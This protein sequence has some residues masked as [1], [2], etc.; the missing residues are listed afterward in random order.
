MAT[1]FSGLLFSSVPVMNAWAFYL[2][3]A[4]LIDTFVVRTL[5]VPAFMGL[6]GDWSWWPRQRARGPQQPGPASSGAEGAAYAKM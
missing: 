4:V 2:V 5:M 6:L 3:V 1:A